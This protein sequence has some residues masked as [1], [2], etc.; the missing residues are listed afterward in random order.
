MLGYW[1]NPEQTAKTLRNG[2]LYTG[3]MGKVDEDGYIYLTDRKNDMIIT[4]GENVYP[5]EVED[6][7]MAHPAVL[8]V[9]VFG[10]PD[11]KWGEAVKAIVACKPGMTVSENELIAFCKES[12][13]GYKCPKSIDFRQSLIKSPIGKILRSEMKKEFW[14]GMDRTIS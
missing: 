3:D 8:E 1:K 12:L 2:W 14:Q 5:R 9:A 4:G 13:A 7:I 6:V 11:Q 10:V